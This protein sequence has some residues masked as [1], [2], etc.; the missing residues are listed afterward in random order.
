ME[1]IEINTKCILYSGRDI[2]KKGRKRQMLDHNNNHRVNIKIDSTQDNIY[3]INEDIDDDNHSIDVIKDLTQEKERKKRVESERW[4]FDASCYLYEYQMK[5]ME[6]IYANGNTYYDD[7]SKIAIQQINRKIYGYKQQ[8]I[9][10][11]LLN[12]S[13]LITLESVIQRMVECRLKCYYCSSEMN[14]L[15]D[16]SRESKQWTVD[17][18]DNN[19]GHTLD[20][21][22]IACLECNLKRRR[23]NDDKYLFTKQ[24]KIIKVLCEDEEKSI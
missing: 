20:N 19:I 24:L 8:D 4:T 5:M 7:I 12:V 23:R 16:I 15:Y 18:I 13:E 17:R 3:N 21:Y 1:P 9:H 11:K 14:V 22:Y 2:V 6:D 10:K